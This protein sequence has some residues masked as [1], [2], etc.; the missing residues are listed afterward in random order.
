MFQEDRL[1]RLGDRR[2]GKWLDTVVEGGPGW[3]ANTPL[4][5][6]ADQHAGAYDVQHGDPEEHVPT[7]VTVHALLLLYT[8]NEETADQWA[9]EVEAALTPQGSP[10]STASGS[11]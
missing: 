1:R 3:S 5:E 11:C 10:S 8:R 2:L 4:R 6:P 9:K 7:P